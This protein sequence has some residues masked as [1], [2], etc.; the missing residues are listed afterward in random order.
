MSD[1]VA[2]AITLAIAAAIL[3]NAFAAALLGHPLP[4]PD[5]AGLPAAVKLALLLLAP[6]I[7]LGSGEHTLA[8]Q[9]FAALLLMLAMLMIAAGIAAALRP[10]GAIASGTSII[11]VLRP[12]FLLAAG[13]ALLAAS[14]L[15]RRPQSM[16]LDG[17]AL[18]GI[19][20]CALFAVAL[21]GHLYGAAALTRDPIAASGASSG[22]GAALLLAVALCALATHHGGPV[23]AYLGDEP[24][25]LAK[26]RM[27]PAA[28]L[29]PVLAGFTLLYAIG[30]GGLGPNLAVAV[31]VFANIVV[32]L[33]LINGAG[34]KVAAL[35]QAKEQKL[36]ARADAARKAVSRD[37][38][39]NLSNRRGWDN[40]VQAAER[41]CEG[42]DV[43]AC[44]WM[45]DLDGL[46]RVN[47]THGHKAGDQLIQAAAAALRLAARRGDTLARLGGDEFAYLVV[48]CD[49]EMAGAISSRFEQTLADAKVPAS[50]GHA[51]TV[52]GNL[53][54]A[55]ESADRAMYQR[56]RARK[57]RRA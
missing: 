48:D 17:S 22:L 23:A 13:I 11:D 44:V 27:L 46:K 14:L 39:T 53:A 54:A 47:D 31:T 52:G 41:R 33:V 26:R 9:R 12:T 8:S 32:M 6:A 29:T 36:T 28:V 20:S 7:L 3:A 55:I 45:I 57:L 5:W 51:L 19:A 30:G 35:A 38:M 49:E 40:A 15:F 10:P 21:V 42:G 16:V 37:P 56:K 2:R 34:N 4:L 50:M 25:A 18:L 43:E 1:V 24:G